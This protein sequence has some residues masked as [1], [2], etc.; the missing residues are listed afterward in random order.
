MVVR[1]PAPGNLSAA[2]VAR[3]VGF[4]LAGLLQPEPGLARE[5]EHG[6]AP[7]SGGRGPLAELCRRVL[8]DV[9]ALSPEVAA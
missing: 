6:Q 1:G 9:F 5:L 2:E 4:P 7:A 8:T 3:S